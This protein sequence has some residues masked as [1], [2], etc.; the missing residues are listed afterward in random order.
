MVAQKVEGEIGGRK[1]VFETGKLAK[2]ANGSVL[3]QYGETVLLVTAVM[4]DEVREGIDF[5][6]LTV[7]F[8]EKSYASGKIPGGFFKREGRPT[9]DA[10][11]YSRLADR[12]IRPF[13]PE[14]FKNEVQV[15]ATILSYDGSNSPDVQL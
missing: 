11:L 6:P 3:L 8:R 1:L 10:T 5:F 15:I 7:E 4:S 9:I 2:Q 12:A 13:F 14:G